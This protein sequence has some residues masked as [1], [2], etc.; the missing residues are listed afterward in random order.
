MALS[1]RAAGLAA[2]CLL[3]MIIPVAAQDDRPSDE[4]LASLQARGRLIAL[5]L[6]A[7][8]R[9][10]ELL[11]AQ[12]TNAPPSDRTVVI[13]EREGW[14]V[15]YLE[16]PTGGA[17]PP[18][19]ARKGLSIVAE[20]TFSPDTGDLGTLGVIVPPRAAPA[21][22]QSYARS[23]DAAEAAVLSHPDGGKPYM[24]AVVRDQDGTFTA[25]VISQGPEEGARSEAAEGARSVLFGRDF[26]IRISAA[27]RQV[28]SV[29]RL[30][31]GLA[32]LSLQPRA[33]GV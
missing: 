16:E 25:Y 32:N 18:G 17:S 23:L 1:L 20:T 15:V 12:R 30:H 22:I 2:T 26:L 5:Y 21:T 10:A 8:D 28:L 33:P 19:S 31:V 6:Q 4:A 13:P 3:G 29:E 7:V 24:D 27:G 14:R 11:K 9:A